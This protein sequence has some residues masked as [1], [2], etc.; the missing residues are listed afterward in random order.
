MTSRDRSPAPRT[1]R[2]AAAPIPRIRRRRANRPRRAPTRCPA[3][4]ANRTANRGTSGRSGWSPNPTARR[5]SKSNPRL[6]KASDR[7]C[8]ERSPGPPARDSAATPNRGRAAETN[9]RRERA[10]RRT[11]QPR[12]GAPTALP[13][14]AGAPLNRRRLVRRASARRASDTHSYPYR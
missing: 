2:A 14:W 9:F 11:R 6:C 7:A 13:R 3:A 12:A 10:R 8:R 5:S 1:N 4:R